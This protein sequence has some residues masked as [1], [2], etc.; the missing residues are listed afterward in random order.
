MIVRKINDTIISSLFILYECVHLQPNYVPTLE[1]DIE[2]ERQKKVKEL[3]ISGKG[4]KVTP[5]SFA[6]WQEG[7]RKVKA[8][9]AKKMVEREL[10]KKKGGKGLGVLS[11]RALYE[12]KRDLFKDPTPEENEAAAAAQIVEDVATKVQTDLFLDGD[13]DVSLDDIDEE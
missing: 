12:Y 2:A 10:R 8:A 7:K 3:K 11:G 9:I 4:T 1:D 6:I 5:E 13:D